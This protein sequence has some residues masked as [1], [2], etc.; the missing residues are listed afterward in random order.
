MTRLYCETELCC[1]VVLYGSVSNSVRPSSNIGSVKCE[2]CKCKC[3]LNI[4]RRGHVTRIGRAHT[5][6]LQPK[7]VARLSV[8]RCH[9]DSSKPVMKV[10][11]KTLHR[12]ITSYLNADTD[13]HD[14]RDRPTNR[15]AFTN[16]TLCLATVGLLHTARICSLS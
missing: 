5:T 1:C 6:R 11:T 13:D 2:L 16:V 9:S 3:K 12:E 4:Q 8:T 7:S 15:T 10:E 14:N